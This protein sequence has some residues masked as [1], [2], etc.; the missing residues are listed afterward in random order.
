MRFNVVEPDAFQRF[1]LV[2]VLAKVGLLALFALGALACSKE[3]K[4]VAEDPKVPA[5]ADTSAAEPEPPGAEAKA[6]GQPQA[7]PP[8]P[9]EPPADL[10]AA[11]SEESFDLKLEP[12]Q[13][14]KVGEEGQLKVVLDAKPPFKVNQEY[15]YSFTLN[16]SPGVSFASQKVT[17]DAVTLEAKRATMVVPFTPKEA[18][19]RTISGTFKF[20]VCTDEQCLIKKHDL[21]LAIHVQ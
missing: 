10:K 12:G 5:R 16:E 17:K 9:A 3:S 8:K 15:P 7:E 14:Y 1:R 2:G 18:G 21:G 4:P 13:T 20:S 11:V 6:A 19:Q